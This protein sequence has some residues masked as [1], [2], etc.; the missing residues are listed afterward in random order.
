[1]LYTAVW[2]F[3]YMLDRDLVHAPELTETWLLVLGLMVVCAPVFL[4]AGTRRTIAIRL[5]VMAGLRLFTLVTLPVSLLFLI[6][7]TGGFDGGTSLTMVL[8]GLVGPLALLT[9]FL[10]TPVFAWRR[11]SQARSHTAG[12]GTS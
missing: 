3:E 8:L 12:D 2:A 5:W 11:T 4:T 10:F 1:L 7:G 9:T 6:G